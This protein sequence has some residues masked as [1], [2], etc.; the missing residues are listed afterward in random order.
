MNNRS[1]IVRSN[2]TATGLRRGCHHG[3]RDDGGGAARRSSQ[4]HARNGLLDP[5]SYLFARNSLRNKLTLVPRLMVKLRG[6]LKATP[7]EDEL[8]AYA[9]GKSLALLATYL[10]AH[11]FLSA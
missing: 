10:L 2:T 11:R 7:Y 9:H 3:R 6:L 8:S 1:I 5:V 4:A